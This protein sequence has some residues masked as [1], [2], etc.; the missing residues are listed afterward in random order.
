MS[1]PSVYLDTTEF[2]N[3]L[4]IKDRRSMVKAIG[5]LAEDGNIHAANLYGDYLIQSVW[6]EEKM[7]VDFLYEKLL[8][9]PLDPKNYPYL[10][11]SRDVQKAINLYHL[12]SSNPEFDQC[13]AFKSAKV[14]ILSPVLV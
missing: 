14:K 13:H 1:E 10:I 11:L 5:S 7:T 6:E 2:I 8:P 3:V 4:T 12:A 9:K